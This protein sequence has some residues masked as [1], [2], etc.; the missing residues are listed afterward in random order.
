MLTGLGLLLGGVLRAVAQSIPGL[1]DFV[2]PEA[3]PEEVPAN[4]VFFSLHGCLFLQEQ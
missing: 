1:R 3:A 4:T 2:P